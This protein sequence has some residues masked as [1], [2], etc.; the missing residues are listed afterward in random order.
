MFGPVQAHRQTWRGPGDTGISES[1]WAMCAHGGPARHEQVLFKND[2]V[3]P[4][5][6]DFLTGKDVKDRNIT[7][8]PLRFVPLDG[9]NS[10]ATHPSVTR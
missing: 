2:T 3:V 4:V 10:T 9:V 6:V 7:Y 5:V 1:P 8:R